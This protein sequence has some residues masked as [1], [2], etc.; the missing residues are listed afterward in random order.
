MS[1]IYGK[2]TKGKA[3][4][5]H[6]VVVR[7]RVGRCQYCASERD[8]QC[9][10][11]VTRRRNATRCDENAALCLCKGCHLRFGLD[12]Y[13]WVQF[14]SGLIGADAYDEIQRRSLAGVKAN[15]AFWQAE[16]TR[17]RALAEELGV[18]P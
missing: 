8:L 6:S 2:G 1:D 11:I 7:A 4:R 12:P 15:E 16:L 3:T 9:A 5:L 10:H 13:A 18:T 14:V 17:L